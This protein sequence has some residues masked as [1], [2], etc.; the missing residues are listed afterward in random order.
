MTCSPRVVEDQAH[1]V[2][3]AAAELADAV[4]HGGLADT[5]PAQHWPLVDREHHRIA[6]AQRNDFRM[7]VRGR[8]LGHHELAAL[9]IVTGF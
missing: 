2:A 7:L 6:L 3:P 8:K 5:T 4:P 9:E 1:S